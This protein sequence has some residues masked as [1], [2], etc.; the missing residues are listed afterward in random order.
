MF[1]D[2]YVFIHVLLALC[3]SILQLLLYLK[4]KLFHLCSLI[5]NIISGLKIQIFKLFSVFLSSIV[6]NTNDT[7]IWTHEAPNF[8]SVRSQA[9]SCGGEKM[10]ETM[11]RSLW[12]NWPQSLSSYHQEPPENFPLIWTWLPVPFAFWHKPACYQPHIY[13]SPQHRDNKPGPCQRVLFR[14]I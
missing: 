13:R 9:W 14:R 1:I 4:G 8:F 12:E 2:I 5:N 7:L 11:F 10:K 3:F 6:I